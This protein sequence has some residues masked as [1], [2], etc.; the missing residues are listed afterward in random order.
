MQ[1]T[2]VDGVWEAASQRYVWNLHQHKGWTSPPNAT[3]MADPDTWILRS[4][5]TTDTKKWR[6]FGAFQGLANAKS[7]AERLD[8]QGWTHNY[9]DE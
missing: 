9:D 5:Y 2:L 7:W 6:Y 4:R 8:Q 3:G 1:W